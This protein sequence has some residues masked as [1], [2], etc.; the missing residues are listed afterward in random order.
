MGSLGQLSKQS[1]FSTALKTTVNEKI[2]IKFENGTLISSQLLRITVFFSDGKLAHKSTSYSTQLP[3]KLKV[4]TY[5]IKAA[6]IDG[7]IYTKKLIYTP[8]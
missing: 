8:F 7:V 5:I 6:D 4:G 1:T 2:K 3:I